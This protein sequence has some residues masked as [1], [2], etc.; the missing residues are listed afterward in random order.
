MRDMEK[1]LEV[2]EKKERKRNV[3]IKEMKPVKGEIRD[4][5]Q[6]L[7]EIGAEMKV[8]ELRRIKTGREEWRNMVTVKVGDEE[9]KKEVLEKKGKLRGKRIWVEEDL[10]WGERRVKWKLRE[11]AREEVMQGRRVVQNRVRIKGEWW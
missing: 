6:L 8:C 5:E 9:E 2:R 7:R 4:V 1:K 3:V 11:I 10:T